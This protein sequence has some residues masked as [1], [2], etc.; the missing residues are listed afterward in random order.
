MSATC[1]DHLARWCSVVSRRRRLLAACVLLGAAASA[2]LAFLSKPTYVAHAGVAILQ[3]RLLTT[4]ELSAGSRAPDE[5]QAALL[6]APQ[7]ALQGSPQLAASYLASRRQ[8]LVALVQNESIAEAVVKRLGKN[9]RP[10]ERAPGALVARV[11][12]DLLKSEA[13]G[14]EFTDIVQI[15]VEGTDPAREALIANLWA[16]EYVDLVNRRLGQ[17][18]DLPVLEVALEAA[19]RDLAAAE[20]ALASFHAESPLE[21]LTRRRAEVLSVIEVLQRGRRSAMAK[22][23]EGLD[24]QALIVV[25]DRDLAPEGPVS[26]AI[27]A[28][29]SKARELMA[30]IEEQEAALRRLTAA[31]DRA[32]ASCEAIGSRLQRLPSASEMSGEE[33]RLLVRAAMPHAPVPPTGG[34][35]VALGATAGLLVGFALAYLL[36]MM[37]AGLPSGP[38]ALGAAEG[39][40]PASMT[41][42]GGAPREEQTTR[43]G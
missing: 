31:R 35:I 18:S 6:A 14:K 43:R 36:G 32:L 41:A 11:R 25:L 22:A 17:C 26:S 20:K 5:L 33:V 30:A 13:D 21:E 39:P 7:S 40:T 42:D 23:G 19:R 8:T 16:T 28:Q 29:E 2:P 12:G 34:Q 4:F 1:R 10:E 24:V 37:G 27:A 15:S 9:A 38:A 3:A